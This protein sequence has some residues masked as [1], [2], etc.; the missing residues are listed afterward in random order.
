MGRCCW[1]PGCDARGLFPRRVLTSFS[2]A[3]G[4]RLRFETENGN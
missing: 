1:D 4:K 3:L 2:G